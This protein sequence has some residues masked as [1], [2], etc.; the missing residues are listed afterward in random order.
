MVVDGV[1]ALCRKV[2]DPRRCSAWRRLYDHGLVVRVKWV[3]ILVE[4]LKNC[5]VCTRAKERR[6]LLMVG[7]VC[8]RG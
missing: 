1:S 6:S 4:G 8:K 5:G 7:R 3:G 2:G